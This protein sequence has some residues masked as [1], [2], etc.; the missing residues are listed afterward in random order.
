M[1]SIDLYKRKWEIL[2]FSVFS[3][4]LHFLMSFDSFPIKRNES[5]MRYPEK[6]HT[7][8]QFINTLIM[9]IIKK[10]SDRVYSK[11]PI[12]PNDNGTLH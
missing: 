3:L 9:L 8:I 5:T 10:Q 1:N 12:V 11:V 6:S 2:S 4:F 7:I